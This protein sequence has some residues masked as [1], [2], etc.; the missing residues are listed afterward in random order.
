[1]DRLVVKAEKVK[2]DGDNGVLAFVRDTEDWSLQRVFLE[3]D[4]SSQ[5]WEYSW[6][7]KKNERNIFDSTMLVI[8]RKE[9]F[10]LELHIEIPISYWEL[11]GKM[12]AVFFFTEVKNDRIVSPSGIVFK[13]PPELIKDGEKKIRHLGLDFFYDMV[14]Q[15]GNPYSP[16]YAELVWTSFVKNRYRQ[17]S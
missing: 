11:C 4:Q 10:S 12:I 5:P 2:K 7:F 8:I 14:L 9:G 6:E 3:A 13:L 15:V 16:Q 17:E 1:M